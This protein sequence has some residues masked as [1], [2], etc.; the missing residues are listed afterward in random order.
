MQNFSNNFFKLF[1]KVS[2]N[3]TYLV[4][5]S[6]LS[7]FGAI[8][9]LEVILR[10]GLLTLFFGGIFR[11]LRTIVDRIPL[12]KRIYNFKDLFF[13]ILKFSI[14][15]FTFFIYGYFLNKIILIF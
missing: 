15:L 6:L 4:V 5:G 9:S 8:L 12:E 10:I 1:T 14:W 7:I 11:I 13:T 3:V 2:V